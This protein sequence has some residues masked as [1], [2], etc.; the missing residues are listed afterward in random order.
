MSS[1]L[2]REHHAHADAA[3]FAWQTEAPWFAGTEAGLLDG[4]SVA[5]GERLL[6]IGCGEGGNL[7]HLGARVPGVMRVGVDVS[8]AK[9]A[10]AR[11]NT[12]AQVV[13]ADA[14]RLPFADHSFDVVLIRDLLHHLPDRAAAL[15]EA[16]RV[17]APGGRLTLIEPNR[18]APLVMLQ[19]ALVPAERGLMVSTVER[20][21]DELAGAGFT[22]ES[23]SARQP[24]PI[25][26]VLLHPKLGL[27]SLAALAPVRAAL[28][29]FDAFARWIVPGR[30]WLYLTFQCIKT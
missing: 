22:I 14:G 13:V 6:E 15:A 16:H 1:N 21:R 8:P 25:A 7:H 26:R 3:H 12:G 23:E 24:F 29:G 5:P 4:L 30:V 27:S 18:R 28:D 19:A 20:L 11:R 17:L 9:A 10:F 2:Q